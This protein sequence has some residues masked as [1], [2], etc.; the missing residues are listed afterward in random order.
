[1]ELTDRETRIIELVRQFP[2][3][4]LECYES[5]SPEEIRT[6][7]DAMKEKINAARAEG[8]ITDKVAAILGQYI[9]GVLSCTDEELGQLDSLLS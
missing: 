5:L 6:E 8:T 2:D 1:M 4:E 3:E 9:D 7:C